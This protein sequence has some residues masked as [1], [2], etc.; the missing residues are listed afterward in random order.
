MKRFVKKNV[1]V[2]RLSSVETLGSVNIICTDKTGTL[3]KNEMTVTKLFVNGEIVD[4]SGR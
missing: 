4:V 1:L 2:R 3:T